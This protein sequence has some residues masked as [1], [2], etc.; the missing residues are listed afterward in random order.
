MLQIVITIDSSQHHHKAPILTK[1]YRIAPPVETKDQ[2]R[3]D[4]KTEKLLN[5]NTSHHK[6]TWIDN[7]PTDTKLACHSTDTKSEDEILN[8]IRIIHKK[9]QSSRNDV[10][11]KYRK[12]LD[13]DAEFQIKL[14]E[15]R[16]NEQKCDIIYRLDT[17]SSL[18]MRK[19]RIQSRS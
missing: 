15:P 2:H 1:R 8:E 10:S 18:Y 4:S 12:N 9:T 11:C 7:K 6:K 13:S 17:A 19:N 16:T 14:H 3:L 5:T